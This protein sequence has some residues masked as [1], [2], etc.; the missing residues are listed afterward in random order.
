MSPEAVRKV[1]N[2]VVACNPSSDKG[3]LAGM[4]VKVEMMGGVMLQAF[5]RLSLRRMGWVTKTMQHPFL[6]CIPCISR[7]L[8]LTPNVALV[9]EVLNNEARTPTVH[10]CTGLHP[11]R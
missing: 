2:A 10:Y 3:R 7:A 9:V 8:A 11:R 1:C 5:S 4:M 6:G